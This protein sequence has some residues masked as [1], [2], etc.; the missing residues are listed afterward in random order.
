MPTLALIAVLVTPIASRDRARV[1]RE[2]RDYA[3]PAA[4]VGILGP[5]GY[6]LVLFA[7]RIAPVSHVAPARELSLENPTPVPTG[8]PSGATQVNTLRI[9]P[10]AW[11]IRKVFTC[12][13][14]DDESVGWWHP[15]LQ[16]RFGGTS[17]PAR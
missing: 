8:L 9:S 4:V 10:C 11:E 14:P 5:P 3:V 12:V 13:A 7:M 16:E 2:L 17:L 6:V 1:L 15:T